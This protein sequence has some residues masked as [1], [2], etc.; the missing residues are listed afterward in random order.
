MKKTSLNAI[1]L[2]GGVILMAA[3]APQA[4]SSQG[5][6]YTFTG[7][8]NAFPSMDT[9]FDYSKPAGSHGDLPSFVNGFTPNALSVGARYYHFYMG[10][11]STAGY[12]LE[13][14]TTMN[15]NF[16]PTDPKLWIR[17]LNDPNVPFVA[18]SDDASG[19]FPMAHLWV[20]TNALNNGGGADLFLAAYTSNNNN[21]D[22]YYNIKR[23]EGATEASCT[24][25]QAVYPWAKLI[26]TTMTTG[27]FK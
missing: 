11:K 20:K 24:T 16:M 13:I 26:G 5:I 14:V 27:N 15:S 17:N 10:S 3:A 21:M 6:D 23:L 18:L 22:L 1:F 19:L 4:Q 2:F 25:G 12:C 9:Y 8:T 7:N